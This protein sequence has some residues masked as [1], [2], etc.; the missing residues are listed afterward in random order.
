MARGTRMAEPN[1]SSARS[2]DRTLLALG[3]AFA[4]GGFYL[5]L[6]GLGL[7]RSPSHLNGPNWLGFA[8]G[9]VL[10]A[11]GLSALV[12]AWL[13]V[14]DQQPNL[15]DD[16]PAIAVAIQWL[17]ALTVIAGLASIGTWIAFG[18]GTRQF[19]VSVPV[20]HSWT[21]IIGRTMFGVGAVITWLIAAVMAYAGAKK[22][23][24]KK[25]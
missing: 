22:I 7:A 6:V 10:F 12:R 1:S 13:R 24:G 16:A 25:N 11:A 21:E 18:A 5:A 23:F 17:A 20:P 9:L 15:P 14:P 8:A 2:F 19:A 3:V 4:S